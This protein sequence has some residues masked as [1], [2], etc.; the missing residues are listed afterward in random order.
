MDPHNVVAAVGCGA[1]V[2]G[3]FLTSRHVY[4]RLRRALRFAGYEPA[5]AYSRAT[6]WSGATVSA[7][8][9]PLFA[10]GG[11]VACAAKRIE[12]WGRNR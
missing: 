2:L 6:R 5:S 4:V 10:F 1:Y 12:R 3:A 7:F 11:G 8:L 9:W